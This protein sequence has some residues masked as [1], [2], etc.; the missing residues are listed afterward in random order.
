MFISDISAVIRKASA[1]AQ[2]NPDSV[3]LMEYISNL[4]ADEIEK[5]DR[6]K[7]IFNRDSFLKECDYLDL[8]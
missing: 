6:N 1:A 2:S 4:F 8:T 7:N 5:D 3:W